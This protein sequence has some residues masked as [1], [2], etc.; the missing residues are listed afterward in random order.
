VG[1]GKLTVNDVKDILEARD[2]RQAPA[3]VPAHG[4]FLVDVQHGDFSF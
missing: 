3:M 2:R 1:K 4:L